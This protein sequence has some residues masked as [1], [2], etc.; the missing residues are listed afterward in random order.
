MRNEGG[1]HHSSGNAWSSRSGTLIEE[2]QKAVTSGTR[3]AAGMKTAKRRTFGTTWNQR[4]IPKKIAIRWNLRCGDTWGAVRI[5]R[6]MSA[7]KRAGP[8]IMTRKWLP[9]DLTSSMEK[10]E[11]VHYLQC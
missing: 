11:I 1:T 5:S 4:R 9:L 8:V 3:T 6:H 10:E 2:A 7:S